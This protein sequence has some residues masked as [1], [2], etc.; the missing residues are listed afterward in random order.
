MD[1]WIGALELFS[2][3][4]MGDNGNVSMTWWQLEAAKALAKG[5]Q[6]RTVIVCRGRVYFFLDWSNGVEHLEENTFRLTKI[7]PARN[8]FILVL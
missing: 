8:F 4:G 1:Q 6:Q 7:L 5:I 2:G 3:G